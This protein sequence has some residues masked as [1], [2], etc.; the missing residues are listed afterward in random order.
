VQSVLILVRRCGFPTAPPASE[1]SVERHRVGNSLRLNLHAR[2]SRVQ[3]GPLR[4]HHD[5]LRDAA[6]LLLKADPGEIT[7]CGAFRTTRS[8]D[9]A[10]VRLQSAQRIGDVL[11]GLH[12]RVAVLR[13]FAVLVVDA[14]TTRSSSLCSDDDLLDQLSLGVGVSVHVRPILSCESAF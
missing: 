7:L 9:G 4:V 12:D 14:T 6:K 3:I 1:G 13:L 8:G 10:R 5:E 2:E 11:E